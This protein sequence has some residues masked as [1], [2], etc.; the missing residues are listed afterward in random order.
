MAMASAI[1][2]GG[3]LGGQPFDDKGPYS[4][5][6]AAWSAGRAMTL[7]DLAVLLAGAGSSA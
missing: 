7:H 2:L 5:P 6:G 3:P 4:D 1:L